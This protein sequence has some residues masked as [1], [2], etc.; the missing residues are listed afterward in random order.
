[1]K[2]ARVGKSLLC[3]LWL[4]AGG[5]QASAAQPIHQL[6]R[7]FGWGWS[8]GYHAYHPRQEAF[9][10]LREPESGLVD[11]PRTPLTSRRSDRR[12]LGP[13]A[14][15]RGVAPA[16]ETYS[17]FDGM[18]NGP[19]A[20]TPAPRENSISKPERLPSVVRLTEPRAGSRT[21]N[22]APPMRGG[23]IPAA[24]PTTE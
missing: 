17:V 6:M 4:F 10:I 22:P 11:P 3:V 13:V 2:I 19:Q 7:W 8:D 24:T 5:Q 20:P 23:A 21:D 1:M 12:L 9:P 15:G 16:F 18:S 14:V